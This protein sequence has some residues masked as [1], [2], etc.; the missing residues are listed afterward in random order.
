L[1]KKFIFQN[2]MEQKTLE[3]KITSNPVSLQSKSQKKHFFKQKIIE[4]LKNIDFIV[5]SEIQIEINWLIHEKDRY[6]HP[7]SPDIDNIIKPILDALSG[8]LIIDDS[9]LQY[10]SCKWIDT[11]LKNQEIRVKLDYWDIT[12]HKNSLIFLEF[13]NSLCIPFDINF[14]VKLQKQHISSW[15]NYFK[16]NIAYE[17]YYLYKYLK[18]SVPFFHKSRIDKSIFKIVSIDEYKI[19]EPS[20]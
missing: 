9:Q 4:Q 13:K 20:K 14:P 15:K 19:I 3:F 10:I 8:E 1:K 17:N 2:K 5:A 18:P 7:S 6:M 16:N 12:Y 11:T